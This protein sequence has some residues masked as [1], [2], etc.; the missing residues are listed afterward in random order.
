MARR[1]RHYLFHCPEDETLSFSKLL[2]KDEFAFE[3]VKIRS[4]RVLRDYWIYCEDVRTHYWKLQLYW[5]SSMQDFY[6]SKAIRKE[7]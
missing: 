7:C 2:N 4:Q 1:I 5:D 6:D 3:L